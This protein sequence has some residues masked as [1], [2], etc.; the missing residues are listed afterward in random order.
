MLVIWGKYCFRAQRF[1]RCSM[2]DIVDMSG[3]SCQLWSSQQEKLKIKHILDIWK[4]IRG[5]YFRKRVMLKIF[6][7]ICT[8][9]LLGILSRKMQRL[10]AKTKERTMESFKREW[11]FEK[12]SLV[13]C[14]EFSLSVLTK[15]WS[16]HTIRS[17]Y[18]A[19]SIEMSLGALS[20]RSYGSKHIIDTL[21]ERGV[22][23]KCVFVC[24]GLM[25]NPL[26]VQ[27][28]T[29]NAF[30]FLDHCCEKYAQSWE[31]KYPHGFFPVQMFVFYIVKEIV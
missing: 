27:Q 29:G 11:F 25:K 5:V 26:F 30:N 23:V 28:H 31:N 7:F 16:L 2:I 14:F 17:R 9:I 20:C 12:Q 13:D 18:N 3:G 4:T 19:W 21:K 22:D 8:F 15:F 10:H 24:G 1:C 6:N